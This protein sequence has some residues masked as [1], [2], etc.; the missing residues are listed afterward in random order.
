M[1]QRWLDLAVYFDL[2]AILGLI[3]SLLSNGLYRVYRCFFAYMA[4]DAVETIL[5]LAFRNNHHIYGNIYLGGQ[6]LKLILAVLVVLELYKVAL[7]GHPALATFG[8]NTVAYLLVLA[9]LV[10]AAGLMLDRIVSR[11][12]V[13][14]FCIVS[15]PLSGPWTRGW[16]SSCS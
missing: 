3:I 1:V 16:S 11:R 10:A 5:G 2:V 7:E 9:A 4:A 8:R 13:L 12:D 6:F 14:R 15:T